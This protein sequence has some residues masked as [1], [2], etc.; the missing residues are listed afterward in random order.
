VGIK[1]QVEAKK[2]VEAQQL[3]EAREQQRHGTLMTGGA[4]D[5]VRGRGKKKRT[6][7]RA[8]F[9]KNREQSVEMVQY[10]WRP[11]LYLTT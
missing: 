10:Y 3:V 8:I 1:Q 2:L 4:S 9:K 6:T 7:S 11:P 5:T